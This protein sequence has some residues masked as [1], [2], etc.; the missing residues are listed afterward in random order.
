[1]GDMRQVP[2]EDLK[3]LGATVDNLVA[4]AIWPGREF[5]HSWP[6]IIKYV[7]QSVTRYRENN[8]FV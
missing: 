3:I 6:F 5:L 1:M 2:T 7:F 4:T 8:Y